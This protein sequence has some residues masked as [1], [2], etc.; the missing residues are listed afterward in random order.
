MGEH[1]DY[2]VTRYLQL[3]LARK[4]LAATTHA[5]VE[6]AMRGPRE[7]HK[8]GSGA[9]S[10]RLT[11]GWLLQVREAASDHTIL[12]AFSGALRSL[13]S[14]PTAKGTHVFLSSCHCRKQLCRA[15]LGSLG[16]GSLVMIT[17]NGGICRDVT[18]WCFRVLS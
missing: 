15:A 5:V 1:L 7:V 11:R 3:S 17:V 9:G 14:P 10:P 16:S 18:P 8:F 12:R 2:K 13:S 4:R 6:G